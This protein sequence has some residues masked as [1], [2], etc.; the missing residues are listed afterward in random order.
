MTNHP[1]YHH[2]YSF[3]VTSKNFFSL[4]P[5]TTQ[6]TQCTIT[7]SIVSINLSWYLPGTLRPPR[8]ICKLFIGPNALFSSDQSIITW[9]ITNYLSAL[10]CDTHLALSPRYHDSKYCAIPSLYRDCSRAYRDK[11]QGGTSPGNVTY[12]NCRDVSLNGLES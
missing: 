1:D 7:R 12:L 10:Y 2:V 5:V 4:Y 6:D 3:V 9:K 8:Q 11:S